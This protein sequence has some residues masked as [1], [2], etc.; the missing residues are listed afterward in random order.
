MPKS[1]KANRC[2]NTK[3][4]TTTVL[5][6]I[7]RVLR[8]N[9]KPPELLK[10]IHNRSK[11]CLYVSMEFLIPTLLAINLIKMMIDLGPSTHERC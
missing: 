9:S 2:T 4:V 11:I 6:Y 5:K 3:G 8:K 1:Y 10:Y 7:A